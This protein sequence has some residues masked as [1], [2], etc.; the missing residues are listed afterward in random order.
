MTDI[1]RVF[2]KRARDAVARWR[3][4]P[5][6]PPKTYAEWV[7]LYDTLDDAKRAEIRAAIEAF[8]RKPLISILVPTNNTPERFLR[9]MID[10]V[11][12]QLYPKWELCIADDVSSD[13]KVKDILEE[14]AAKDSRI[15]IV[16]RTTHGHISRTT[17]DAIAIATG[18]HFALVD[19][20]DTLPEHAIF[21]VVRAINRFPNARLL[22]SDEDKL[23]FDGKRTDPY[24]KPDWNPELIRGQ[25]TFSHLGVFEAALVREVGGFRVGFEGSQDH[26]LILRSVDRAGADAV[27][28]IPHVLYHWR[29]VHGSASVGV[30]EKPYAVIATTRAVQD[31]LERCGERG[32]VTP[33]ID[34]TNM[35]RVRYSLPE[36]IPHVSIVF[37]SRDR[38][39]AT[40]ASIESVLRKT[41]YPHYEILV[42]DNASTSAAT[43]E[44]YDELSVYRNI[45]V[46]RSAEHVAYNFPALVNRGA[47]EANGEYLCILDDDIEVLTPD[48][49]HELVSLAVR[50][51]CGAIGPMLWY[52]DET[53]QHGGLV[54]GIGSLAGTEHH[55]LPRLR[56]VGYLG[57]A[58]LTHDV[59]AVSALGM[60]V[61]KAIFDRV[62]GLN[63]IDLATAFHDIDFC[64]R[65]RKAGYRNLFAP[66]AELRHHDR[67][68]V[69]SPAGW[70]RWWREAAWMRRTWAKEVETDPFY[71]PNLTTDVDYTFDLAFPPRIGI[72]D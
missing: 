4:P 54:V 23:G 71:N 27:V 14:Y 58:K 67:D 51:Q 70:G 65:L 66:H 46:L 69:R 34:H 29:M 63:E 40:R 33:A 8:P 62:S 43:L 32:V 72:L 7:R 1:R 21:M 39:G 41:A 38:A 57:R 9:E 61:E 42:V 18:E 48:W 19:H 56:H 12:A 55:R 10:S 25:N 68:R 11:R 53:V 36:D 22:Y 30:D 13:P 16:F 64:L 6:A 28:H 35:M 49:L 60:L 3:E 5:P 15:K 20:D 52:R 37:P 59:T 26:D 24:F 17:N 47:R 45:R 2:V 44:L 31:H 50:R